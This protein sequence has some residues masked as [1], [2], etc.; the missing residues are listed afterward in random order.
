MRS[1]QSWDPTLLTVVAIVWTMVAGL[2]GTL[3]TYYFM[4]HWEST[5]SPGRA[6]SP[7]PQAVPFTLRISPFDVNPQH[8]PPTLATLSQHKYTPHCSSPLLGA[9][10]S[11]A[12]ATSNSPMPNNALVRKV[13]AKLAVTDSPVN[14]ELSGLYSPELTMS[15]D[16]SC[17]VSDED[18]PGFDGLAPSTLPK[19]VHRVPEDE[20]PSY[21]Y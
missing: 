20:N 19:F 15:P 8:V 6:V 16:S 13:L 5:R 11:P 12:L 3:A 9:C 18:S 2:A 4:H 7:A 1:L 21:M 17:S 10:K 14:K